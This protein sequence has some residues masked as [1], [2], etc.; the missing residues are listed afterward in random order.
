MKPVVL[1]KQ[2]EISNAIFYVCGPPGM[3]K[4]IERR[5]TAKTIADSK[6]RDQRS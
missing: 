6:G 3:V 2:E 1:Q 4:A 5:F